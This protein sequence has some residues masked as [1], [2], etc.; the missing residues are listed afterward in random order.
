MIVY[1]WKLLLLMVFNG[2]VINGQYND[3]A[4]MQWYVTLAGF[5]L[6]AG[7]MILILKIPKWWIIDIAGI[8]MGAGVVAMMGISFPLLFTILLMVLLAVYDAVAVY[9]TKHMI[10][11]A[12]AVVE[13]KMPILLVFP[14]KLSY[15]YEDEKNLMDPKRKRESMFMGLRR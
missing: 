2:V 12:D 14:M 1:L 7:L 13:S 9:K 3:Q 15:R 5:T 8:L 6:A 10:A 4:R 11:L